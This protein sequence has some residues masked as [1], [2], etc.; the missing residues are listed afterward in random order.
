MIILRM[1]MF[2]DYIAFFGVK[3]NVNVKKNICAY[4]ICDWKKI[5]KIIKIYYFNDQSRLW[6]ICFD[7][8]NG[9]LPFELLWQP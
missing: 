1:M 8:S 9:S 2:M 5:K 7:Y 4:N 3:Y 6:L